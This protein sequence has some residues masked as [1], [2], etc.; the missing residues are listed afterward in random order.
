[1]SGIAAAPARHDYR[2]FG[3]DI[4]SDLPLPATPARHAAE[5]HVEIVHGPTPQAVSGP[6]AR[7]GWF[8]ATPDRLLLTIAGIGRYLVEAG[9]R[10]T[11]ERQAGATDDDVRVFLLGSALGALL[12]QR[13]VLVLHG[14]A[15][16]VRGRAV[17]FLGPCG[18]GKSTLATALGQ[19]GYPVITD[20]LCVVGR[21]PAGEPVLEPGLA[22][23]KLR[24]DALEHL[25]IAPGALPLVDPKG[26]KRA[27][28][29]DRARPG[30]TLPIRKL[31]ELRPTERDDVVVS[32][33]RGARKFEAVLRHTYRLAFI[34]GLG[35]Q[36]AHFRQALDLAGPVELAT[37]ERPAAAFR[38]GELADRIVADLDASPL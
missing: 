3:L 38:L 35:V 10:I 30:G 26:G 22:R 28:P 7:P 5:P 25:G 20:D 36:G 37:I 32:P 27:W 21:G 19:R 14:S 31:Y 24:A 18:A 6:S 16:E 2:A 11:I 34:E 29:I 13:Q 4:R 12:H 1:V 23:T 17:A 15:V 8:E 33:L 9:R